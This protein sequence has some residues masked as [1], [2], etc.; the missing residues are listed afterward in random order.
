MTMKEFF[1]TIELAK[2]LKISRIAIYKKVKSGKIK[3]LRIGR[4]YAI[5]RDEVN[6]LVGNILGRPLNDNEKKEIEKVIDRVIKEY[7]E[8]LKL[9]GEE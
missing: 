2:M 1:S 9:L 5:P 6:R 4:N 7:G 8:T 3:A